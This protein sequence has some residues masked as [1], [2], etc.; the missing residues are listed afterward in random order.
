MQLT[1]SNIPLM[2]IDLSLY[3]ITDYSL[4]LKRE[5]GLQKK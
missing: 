2:E 3:G 4:V 5:D 1:H